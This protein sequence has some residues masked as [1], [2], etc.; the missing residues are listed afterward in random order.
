MYA[1][2]SIASSKQQN[3]SSEPSN[4]DRDTKLAPEARIDGKN[5]IKISEH[6]SVARSKK[7]SQENFA[8]SNDGSHVQLTSEDLRIK[9]TSED[10][11]ADEHV[12]QDSYDYHFPNS[13]YLVK[14]LQV[15]DATDLDT[16]QAEALR[17]PEEQILSEPELNTKSQDDKP[18][19]QQE[20]LKSFESEVQIAEDNEPSD[21]RSVEVFEAQG[22]APCTEELD[23]DKSG[24][25]PSTY[26]KQ[27]PMSFSSP[28]FGNDPGGKIDSSI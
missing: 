2:P 10:Y 17:K 14:E 19:E 7:K 8:T 5:I 13:S 1:G 26:I 22:R 15:V 20:I 23:Y 3:R 16:S 9:Q 21:E 28:N 25:K 11:R 27:T 4:Q 24:Q 12:Q 6:D 18:N